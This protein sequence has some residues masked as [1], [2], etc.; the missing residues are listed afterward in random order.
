[1]FNPQL[2]HKKA[3]KRIGRYLTATRYKGLVLKPSGML[4]VDAYPDA[5]FAGMYGHEKTTD[6]ACTKSH[7]GFLILVSDSPM[8][9]VSKLQTETALSMME[10]EIIALA[11]C[12]RELFP[13][14]D[15]V[16]E[17]GKV[18]GLATEDMVSMPISIHKDNA[19]ALVL[20]ETIPP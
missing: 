19:G 20:A 12:C 14:V 13:V 1:M 3:L 11:N 10:A 17:I 4:K 15:I 7:T 8:V 16:L 18:V 2:L 6:P 5:D 9:W